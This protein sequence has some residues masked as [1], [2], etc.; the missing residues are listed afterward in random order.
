M[1]VQCVPA[2]GQ[3]KPSK[4]GEGWNW[5]ELL[6]LWCQENPSPAEFWDQTPRSFACWSAG[7]AKAA[8]RANE[9]RI[10]AA[11]TGAFFQRT[12]RLRKLDYYLKKTRPKPKART[13]DEMYRALLMFQMGGAPINI[14]Q[15]N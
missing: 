11:Y 9:D 2:G 6:E 14:R 13:P 4:A 8:Q 5:D 12:E 10:A 7:R 15:V 3:G 1:P